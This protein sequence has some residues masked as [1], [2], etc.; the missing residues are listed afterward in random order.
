M[1]ENKV[2]F[3]LKNVHYALRTG[4]SAQGVPQWSTPVAVA[5]AVNLTLSQVGNENKFY[6]DNIAFYTSQTNQGYSGDLEIARIPDQMLQDIWG[7]TLHAT[8]KTLTESNQTNTVYFALLFQ[9]DGDEDNE[10]HVLYNCTATRPNIEGATATD[11]K[12]PKTQTVSLSA[13]PLETSGGE[14]RA[15]TTANTTSTVKSGWFTT[16]YLAS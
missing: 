2:V 4:T 14:V 1:P 5:G 7:L 13:T 6:A 15:R 9:I 10:Y 16:V 11:T 8:D 12:E 3:G